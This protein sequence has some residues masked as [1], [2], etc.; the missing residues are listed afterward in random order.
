MED[1]W[2]E[3]LWTRYRG[4]CYQKDLKF[5]TLAHLITDA[6]LEH[7]V[8]GNQAFER[9]QGRDALPVSIASTYDKLGHLPLALSEALLEEGTRRMSALLPSSPAVDPLPD[10]WAGHEVFGADGKVVK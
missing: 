8:S 1:A 2:L 10:C 9:A 3:D 4:R 7:Q 5:S 6:L